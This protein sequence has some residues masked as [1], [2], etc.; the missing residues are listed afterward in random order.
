MWVHAS[1]LSPPASTNCDFSLLVA[2]AFANLNVTDYK[3]FLKYK[4]KDRGS[5]TLIANRL[6][7]PAT[8]GCEW[9]KL[10]P[11]DQMPKPE[12]VAFP[13][14]PKAPDGSLMYERIPN[15][16][17]EPEKFVIPNTIGCTII[18]PSNLAIP[19]QMPTLPAAV[20]ATPISAPLPPSGKRRAYEMNGMDRKLKE[21][22]ESKGNDPNDDAFSAAVAPPP[23]KRPNKD[24][25]PSYRPSP[26]QYAAMIEAAT[27]AGQPLPR[28]HVRSQ[29]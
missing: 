21:L 4:K 16:V 23:T 1:S 7:N 15:K 19:P 8:T 26:E 9:L 25:M 13:K 5:V 6:G 3:A 28:T 11:K 20:T 2:T 12:K 24:P 14:P 22:L 29:I 10:T 17:V 18:T 27:A